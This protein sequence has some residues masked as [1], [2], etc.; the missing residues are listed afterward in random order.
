M[1][2]TRDI[3]ATGTLQ[4]W[5]LPVLQ[6]QIDKLNRRSK[7]CG[8]DPMELV[9]KEMY[10]KVAGKDEMGQDKIIELA[11]VV[12]YGEIPRIEGYRLLAKI[13][14]SEVKGQNFVKAV[15]GND[16]DLDPAYRTIGM[17]CDHC[18]HQRRRNDVFVIQNLETGE[19]KI[20]GRNCAA[21][22]CRT[23]DIE[24]MI[25]WADWV[26]S[27]EEAVGE[28]YGDYCGGGRGR[29]MTA[30]EYYLTTVSLCIRKLGWMSRSK[31]GEF[32]PEATADVVNYLLWTTGCGKAKNEFIRKKELYSSDQDKKLAEDALEWIRNLPEEKKDSDYMYN[33]YLACATT[34]VD[35]SSAGLVASLIPAYQ[36]EI[37]AEIKRAKLRK[38]AAGR[39]YIGTLKKR[40]RDLPLTVIGVSSH[41]SAF[42]VKTF[43][44]FLTD[45]ENLVVWSASGDRTQEFKQGHKYIVDATPK[46]HVDH[47]TFGK[48]TFVNRV[49]IK[50]ELGEV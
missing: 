21:D 10:T 7:K 2:A 20:I 33:L 8:T 41:D 44:R 35:H 31:S 4:T 39:E 5:A 47:E 45:E 19:E 16:R 49:T 3:I 26:S 36:R 34:F 28:N 42:G 9:T 27:V 24:A 37:E 22:Y 15:P 1:I 12:V 48:Q 13:T 40:M 6:A 17:R 23:A 11:D 32:G 46:D 18:N 14:P 25:E 38:A 50:Q 29:P 43:I 30:I